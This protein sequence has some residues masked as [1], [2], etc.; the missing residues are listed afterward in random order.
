MSN[1]LNLIETDFVVLDT[2]TT[3]L[4]ERA[5]IVEL[6]II[7]KYGNTLFNRLVKPKGII[8]YDA[9]RIHGISND[10]VADAPEWRDVYDQAKAVLTAEDRMVAIY[11]AN[12]DTRMIRQ[13]CGLH[14][15]QSIDFDSICIMN[16]YTKHWGK[17]DHRR[18]NYKWQK[19][20]DAVV[21]QGIEIRN[22]HRALGDC[23]MT[24]EVIR[25]MVRQSAA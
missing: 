15:L 22:A 19:L 9:Q 20:T 21:Q 17:W 3:G 10:D 11:N 13:T 25:A 8:P 18:N 12:Y 24:L 7:D 16:A 2:E 14:S 1:I 5:E 4:D 23:L 6:A